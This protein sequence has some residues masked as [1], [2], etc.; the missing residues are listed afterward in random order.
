MA[1][2]V[3]GLNHKTAPVE[4]R[5]WVNF[6]PEQLSAAYNQLLALEE[7]DEAAILSTCNR[8]EIYVSGRLSSSWLLAD[9]L[10]QFHG[11]SAGT[12]RGRLYCHE[13]QQMVEHL[14]A[15]AAGLDSMV[16]G[17]PQI[18]GQVKQAYQQAR[19]VGAIGQILERLF[20]QTFAVAKKIRSETEIGASAVSVAYAAVSLAKQ[21]F[22]ALDETSALLVGAGETI[23]LVAKHLATGGCR[24][25]TV[26]NRT[27]RRA[28]ELAA[29]FDASVCALDDIPEQLVHAD[30]VITSTGSSLPI[31]GKG[32]VEAA[33]KQRRHR[34]MFMVDLAVPA[35]I[36]HQVG[37]L[38]DVYLYNVDHLKKVVDENLRIRE[39]ARAEALRIVVESAEAFMEWQQGLSHV[40]VIRTFRSHYENLCEQ[41]LKRALRLLET[42]SPEQV[43]RQLA[44]RLTNKFLHRPT[45]F[46][47][48][49]SRQAETDKV[50]QLCEIFNLQHKNRHHE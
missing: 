39:T 50:R 28:E 36:E 30:L 21:I 16:L 47:Q 45:R 23:E 26:A 33:L 17:E 35:D 20:Q 27:R 14:Y 6:A 12:L 25:L 32:M 48:D 31:I 24:R 13:G 41:E 10:E 5:G 42:Q 2:T 43:V 19:E 29:Q 44:H 37:E 40:D 1:L 4:V 7:V 9:W 46:L 11:L 18:L 15:V 49:A 8:T 22:G 3:L 34:P 38:R